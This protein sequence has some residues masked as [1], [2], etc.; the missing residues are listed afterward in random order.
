MTEVLAGHRSV[1]SP[2]ASPPHASCYVHLQQ[3]LTNPQISSSIEPVTPHE[4]PAKRPPPG[5]PVAPHPQIHIPCMSMT[6]TSRGTLMRSQ[7][8]HGTGHGG[9]RA[10]VACTA[11]MGAT[12]PT[13]LGSLLTSA[14][15][16]YKGIKHRSKVPKDF[17]ICGKTQKPRRKKNP[18]LIILFSPDSL[19][20]N[21]Q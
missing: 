5:S 11:R 3:H 13:G 7:P 10:Q 18:R 2:C 4:E 6:T 17:R 20:H 14:S 16:H 9:R 21:G 1:S 19:S 8:S 12:A 15:H